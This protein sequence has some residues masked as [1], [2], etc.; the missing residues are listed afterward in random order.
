MDEEQMQNAIAIIGIAGRFPKA[1]NIDEFWQNLQAGRECISFFS[2]EDVIA[3]GTD[4]AFL[5]NPHFVKAFG[6]LDDIELFDAQFFGISPREAKLLDPQ[7]RLFLECAWEALEHA[8]YDSERY[9]G[10]ISVF[11]GTNTSTYLFRNLIPN[12]VFVFVTADRFEMALTNNKDVMPMRASYQMNLKGAS[13]NVS[14]TCS[15]SLVA[16]H[17]ACQNL[18]TYQCDMVLAGG[19]HVRVP[20]KEGYLFQEGMIWSPDGHIRTFD[21]KSR[22]IVTGNGAGV[23]VLK[24][25]EDALADGDTIHAIIRG[26]A[27]NN[28]GSTK[29][30]YTAPSIDGQAES[31]A[32]AIAMAGIDSETISYVEVHG[33]GTELGDPVEFAS[34]SKAF[35]ATSADP[36]NPPRSYCGIGSVKTNIGHLN[37]AAGVAGL[38]KTVLAL[39][40]KAIPPSLNF[41]TPN[42][43]IDF[44]N[45]PFYVASALR[46]WT[47]NGVPRRAGVN[48]FGVGGTN[49]HVVLEEAPEP[50]PSDTS[51]P[52]QVLLLST[53]TATA[54]ETAT[55]NL[56]HHLQQHPE[57]PLADVAYTLQTGRKPMEQRRMLVCRDREDAITALTGPDP[58]RVFSGTCEVDARPVVFMFSGQGAQ[59][60]NMGRDLYAGEPI[61]R[62]AVDRCCT[63]LHLHLGF[64][65][66]AL[67]YPDAGDAEA[68]GGKLQQ[69]AITQPALFVIEYTLAQLWMA[70]G[71]RPHALVG[72]SIGEY[73]AD[74]LAGVFTLEDAL[75]L[76]ALRGQMMQ[77]MPPGDMLAVPLAAEELQPLLGAELSLAVI[78]GPTTCVAAGAAQAIAALERR[79]TEKDIESTRLH[80]SHAFHSAMM[81]PLVEP[82]TARVQQMTLNPPQ[83]PYLSNVSGTWIT[84][85][86]ATDPGYWARHL[87]QTVRFAD[88]LA[89][90]LHDPSQI[91]L[92]VGPG[93]TLS[94]L[95]HLHPARNREQVVL[96]SLRHPQDDQPDVAFVLTTLGKI[97]LNGGSVDWAALYAGE[98]R[99]RVPLPTYPFERRRYWIG[100]PRHAE[101]PRNGTRQSLSFINDLD[102]EDEPL[103]SATTTAPVVAAPRNWQEEQL[104]AVWKRFFGLQQIGIH[105]NFF[106]L[107]GSSFTA[108]QLVVE[109]SQIFQTEL[110]LQEFLKAPTIAE[111][112]E[113]ITVTAPPEP[114]TAPTPSVE[115]A[116][117]LIKLKPGND[118]VRPLF[119]VHP[120]EGHVFFYQ[121]LAQALNADRP[122]YAFQSPGLADAAEP[123]N[124]IE[125]MA[126]HYLEG[127]RAVQPEGPYLLGGA[128]F[129]GLVAFEMARQ[130]RALNQS[131]D[132]LFLIDTPAVGQPLFDLE[133]DA[134]I[135]AFVGSRLLQL[136]GNGVSAHELRTIPA[137]EQIAYLLQ[138]VENGHARGFTLPQLE[139]LL[140]VIKANR[141]ALLNY[142]PQPYPGRIIFFRAQETGSNALPVRPEHFWLDLA[143]AGIE[144]NPVP[145][146]HFTMNQ[147][148]HVQQIAVHLERSLTHTELMVK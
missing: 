126:Q 113:R 17:L 132:R 121:D 97:W 117:A 16:I 33:T 53:K 111:L 34:V 31:T 47:T 64:D 18:L 90:L 37:H 94:T 40:H 67:L 23:V 125:T 80:T 86:E 93:R 81:E 142:A 63:I 99:Y 73:V 56:A 144:I 43:R 9:P 44:A 137:E 106:E 58:R 36:D 57:L 59:Y 74:C 84:P 112:A 48:S 6:V 136:N 69:T 45:S 83:I 4:P 134:A 24:R 28:D 13:V 140:R 118:A 65:L 61:F 66:R 105:D 114:A 120:I 95:V 130:L 21:A 78:N 35:Q 72:H 119:L 88:N 46:E 96:T 38:I 1:K 109:L 20:Q 12:N 123:V 104:A 147:Q 146:N 54:L 49:A 62:E 27:S 75:E 116:H 141:E 108:G 145:G 138:R 52:W 8:G 103:T 30:G 50:Q 91:L 26:T 110:S 124:Q 79:L 60:V 129:G 25:L 68:A 41:E 77:S 107:G 92:E 7:H 39:K 128:S 19:S 139:Q 2:D 143:A 133:D 127:L 29:I 135:L 89:Q 98:R 15:T 100:T 148:P 115:P 102:Q 14:T 22:G 101:I 131:V 122:V 32:E 10:R 11:A 42:P 82:F 51:R 85:E 5:S 3:S 76:V 70:W 55:A 87:R 71:V